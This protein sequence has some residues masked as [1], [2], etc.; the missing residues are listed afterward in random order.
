MPSP[1][2]PM[3]PLLP[4]AAWTR[5]PNCGNFQTWCLLA[6]C[7]GTGVAFGL[8]R[9]VLWTRCGCS[10]AETCALPKPSTCVCIP[11]HNP[12][13]SHSAHTS[14]CDHVQHECICYQCKPTGLPHTQAVVTASGDKTLRL[15]STFD[16]SCLRSFEGHTAAVLRVAFCS[17]GGQLLSTGGDGALRLWDARTGEGVNSWEAHEDKGWALECVSDGA[18]VVTGGGDGRVVVWEDSTAAEA[19]DAATTEAARIQQEQ[20]LS[21]AMAEGRAVEAAQLAFSLRQPGRLLAVVQRALEGGEADVLPAIVRGAAGG[22]AAYVCVHLMVTDVFLAPGCGGE[23]LKMLLSYT[24]EWNTNS[25]TCHAAQALLRVV[26][27]TVPMQSLVALPGAG[28]LLAGLEA[29]G[30]RHHAR[31]ERLQQASC[32]LDYM[33]G[34][35]RV[36]DAPEAEKETQKEASLVGTPEPVVERRS[37]PS[38]PLHSKNK[39]ARKK[40]A[41]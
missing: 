13:R 27:T 7:V 12:H 10:G 41:A 8:L 37:M 3:M 16:G 40:I 31:L 21:L 22:A 29:Y 15:W 11:G 6:R 34:S 38:T 5:L 25:R 9:S 17:G 23:D 33:L 20:A 39:A 4:R 26:L 14:C 19:A 36:L 1:L 32:V 2:R 35:M 28:D 24:R 18:A 30:Q